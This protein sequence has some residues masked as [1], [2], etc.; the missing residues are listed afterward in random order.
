M[1]HELFDSSRGHGQKE[2][3]L[4]GNIAAAI[5]S[6]QHN[7]ADKIFREVDEFVG[8][9]GAASFTMLPGEL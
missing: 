5:S 4:I 9:V 6:L 8:S 3:D 2:V 7:D 1:L